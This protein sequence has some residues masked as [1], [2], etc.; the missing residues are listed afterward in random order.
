[1]L[2]LVTAAT[3][4]LQVQVRVTSDTARK[5][6]TNI[7]VGVGPGSRRRPP[8]EPRRI[9]VTAEDLRTAFK[10]SAARELLLHARVARMALDSALTSYD[11][12]SYQRISAGLG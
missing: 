11:A 12:M 3:F 6:G 1:M 9:P 10:D 4:A 5:Q 8:G 7:T 2:A